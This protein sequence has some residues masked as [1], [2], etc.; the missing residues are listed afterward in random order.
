MLRWCSKSRNAF[1][2][3][4]I[5]DYVFLFS[6]IYYISGG[7]KYIVLFWKLNNF[8]VYWDKLMKFTQFML[9]S[10]YFNKIQARGHWSYGFCMYMNVYMAW[11]TEK[12]FLE[13]IRKFRFIQNL[14]KNIIFCNFWPKE[15]FSVGNVLFLL[16]TLVAQFISYKMVYKMS[17]L[18]R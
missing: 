5:F 18:P 14:S 8:F 15:N 16:H 7:P 4:S 12:L 11:F 10:L 6:K 9:N 17:Y 3:I 2:Y 1:F 13:K